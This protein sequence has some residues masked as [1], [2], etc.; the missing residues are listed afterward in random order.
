M[1]DLKSLQEIVK[2]VLGPASSSIS[3]RRLGLISGMR[4]KVEEHSKTDMCIMNGVCRR[5]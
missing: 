3:T 4:V 2:Q 1:D 5:V